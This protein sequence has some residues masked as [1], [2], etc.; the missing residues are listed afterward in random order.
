MENQAVFTACWQKATTLRRGIFEA[1]LCV[2]LYVK[3]NNNNKVGI[4]PQH[5][6]VK[7]EKETLPPHSY[8]LTHGFPCVP[9]NTR[10]W[11]CWTMLRSCT[12]NSLAS[13]ALSDS[14]FSAWESWLCKDK[15]GSHEAVITG[16]SNKA[17]QVFSVRL[18]TGESSTSSDSSCL[19][20]DLYAGICT[21]RFWCPNSL[22]S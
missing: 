15:E 2:C 8:I 18:K 19:R 14:P 16:S 1:D 6:K 9:G 17:T 4:F 5:I 3:N 7:E 11:I 22:G 21:G 13:L 10:T 12:R 20:L